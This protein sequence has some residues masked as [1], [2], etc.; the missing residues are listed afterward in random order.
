MTVAR[1]VKQIRELDERFREVEYQQIEPVVYA[2]LCELPAADA[3]QVARDY[4]LR[5]PNSKAAAIRDISRAIA[6][7]KESWDRI[8][9]IGR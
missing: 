1:A 3:V 2:I 4:G 8:C 6:E 7:R 9:G 5:S